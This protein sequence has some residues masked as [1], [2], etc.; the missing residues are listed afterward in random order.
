MAVWKKKKKKGKHGRLATFWFSTF[1]MLGVSAHEALENEYV[2]LLRVQDCEGNET[3]Q[4]PHSQA[5]SCSVLLTAY[6]TFEPLGE[7]GEGLVHLLRHQT[8]RWTRS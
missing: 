6:V 1:V 2:E 4:Y 3:L 8:A 5:V 7:A